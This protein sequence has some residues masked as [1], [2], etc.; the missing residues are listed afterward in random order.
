MTETSLAHAPSRYARLCLRFV[1]L[2]YAD[3]NRRES[4]RSQLRALLAELPTDGVGLNIGAGTSSIDARVKNLDL[5][6]VRP[7]TALSFERWRAGRWMTVSR[8]PPA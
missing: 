7:A 1:Q 3:H 2:V 8:R 5:V 6:P 4:V